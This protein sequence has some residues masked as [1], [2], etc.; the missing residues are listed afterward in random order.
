MAARRSARSLAWPRTRRPSKPTATTSAA[1]PTNATR[2]LVW[3]VV[4]RRPTPRTS[5]LS[6]GSG[7][8]HPS[9]AAP[10]VV[11]PA[12]STTSGLERRG[13]P[14][15]VGDQPA[16][17]DPLNVRVGGGHELDRLLLRVGVVAFEEQRSPVA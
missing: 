12:S 9:G 4:G 10:P 6:P 8:R 15:Q 17:L 11:G 2:S 16:P 7:A 1:V 3:T 14:G 13:C 5:G